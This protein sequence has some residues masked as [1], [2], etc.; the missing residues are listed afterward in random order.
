[1]AN[2]INVTVKNATAI[3]VKTA[4]GIV[5][6]QGNITL[7]DV[8][9]PVVGAQGSQGLTG[10][11]G[12]TGTQGFQGFQG[13][14][15]PQ[16][17]QGR[18]GE[19][20]YSAYGR[21]Y[22]FRSTNSDISGYEEITTNVSPVAQDDMFATA[23]NTTGEVLIVS[24]VTVANDPGIT[25]LPAGEWEFEL[26]RR[27]S[28]SSYNSSMVIRV[29]KRDISNVETEIFNTTTGTITDE[30][31]TVQLLTYTT[32]TPTLL[33]ESDR[34]VIK[35]FASSDSSSGVV[36][37][38]VHDGNIT[39]SNVRTP[40]TQ[41]IEGPQG[42]QGFQGNTGSQG[43]QGF[44]GLTGPQGFQGTTGSQ[45]NQGSQG[46]VGPQGIQGSTGPQGFQ[47]IQGSTGPQGSQGSQGY[48][49]DQGVMGPQGTGPQGS[50]GPQG[51]QGSTGPQGPQG[52][53]GSTGPQGFQGDQGI[54]GSTGPQGPQGFQ[55]STGPQ[56]TQGTTGSQGALQ[57]WSLKSSNYTAID[58]D[59]LIVD[60]SGG[61]FT[62]TLP[63][64]PVS[65]AYVQIT[66]GV[67]LSVN[68]LIVGRNGSTIEGYT[69]D[70]ALTIKGTTY[71]FI[72]NG[73]TW[74]VTATTGARGPSGIGFETSFLLMG[75]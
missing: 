41:G 18:Q 38:F 59:R 44:Q 9:V 2:T 32:Q 1:M 45:G 55:G 42:P 34:L 30:S 33:N 67:D 10:P 63:A 35:M 57:P 54:Q 25:T 6:P 5:Q 51:T 64:T 4:N 7:R 53:Q 37:H 23:N 17:A 3:T 52:I 74:Q 72:Y 60:T 73:V 13:S 22:Y 28:S 58:G 29:Y 69:D 24:F 36:V 68:S 49:G 14:T 21:I 65:G 62:I 26:Y 15:G 19:V 40:I 61:Q 27:V 47:G 43:S 70:V 20:G 12:Q 75:A 71:E 66:D 31:T 39:A 16:G 11:Q 50:T 56:G 48:Q 46:V 8:T